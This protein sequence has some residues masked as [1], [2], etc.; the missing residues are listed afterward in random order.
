MFGFGFAL[1]PLY[2][3]FCSLTGLN[4]KTANSAANIAGAKV[5]LTRKVRIE[6]VANLN[7][8]MP[9]SFKPTLRSM[10]VHPGQPNRISYIAENRTDNDMVGQAVPSVSPGLAASYLQKSE[11]FCFTEQTL[12]AREK[13]EM[14]VI[15]II[16][17]SIPEDV[18]EMTL[19]YTFFTKKV[20]QPPK[21]LAYN[22][23]DTDHDSYD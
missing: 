10:E 4:G 19:S 11:C 13:K 9:W 5:D 20:I 3:V 12:K 16:D 8:N 1:V 23:Q 2:N 21:P 17:S 22:I 6:F 15:F 14:P 18:H 7:E